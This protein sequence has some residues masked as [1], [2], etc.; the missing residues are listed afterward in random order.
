MSARHSRPAY[1][2]AYTISQIYRRFKFMVII[3]H[4]KCE[5][6][7]NLSLFFQ[8]YP[9]LI[10]INRRRIGSHSIFGCYLIGLQFKHESFI[11]LQK[12]V[13]WFSQCIYFVKNELYSN[14]IER[15]NKNISNIVHTSFYYHVCLWFNIWKSIFAS[16]CHVYA[17]RTVE[18]VCRR[19]GK[20]EHMHHICTEMNEN[21]SYL[22]SCYYCWQYSASETVHAF[23]IEVLLFVSLYLS[24]HLLKDRCWIMDK[25]HMCALCVAD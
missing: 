5:K 2:C 12:S 10:E 18:T 19:R 24:L 15:L 4:C 23:R 20:K 16:H 17:L 25:W 8:T 21:K 1:A 22:I 11:F 3:T 9:M 6:L 13:F 14:K 7:M